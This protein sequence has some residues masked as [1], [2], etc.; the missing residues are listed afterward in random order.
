MKNELR[1]Y[2]IDIDKTLK[3]IIKEL[4]LINQNMENIEKLGKTYTNKDL[5][6]QELNKCRT[7]ANNLDTINFW[8]FKDKKLDW[9]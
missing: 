9:K 5:L 4:A 6:Y 1:D 7:S 3:N 8:S 2:Y